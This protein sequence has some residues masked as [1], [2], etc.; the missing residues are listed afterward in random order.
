MIQHMSMVFKAGGL[1]V[2][3]GAFLMA[4]A[5]HTDAKGYV[6]AHMQQI[7]DE[8]HM[9][10]RSARD[11]RKRLEERELVKAAPRFSPKNNAQIANLFRINLDLLKSMERKRTDYGP[12]LVEEL[13]FE[14]APE[15]T[16]SSDPPAK[17]AAPSLDPPADLAPP[18]ADLAP[19][20]ADLAGAGAAKSAALL[21]PSS[22]P[23]SLSPRAGVAGDADASGGS[24]TV[25][26]RENEASPKGQNPS[27]AEVPQQREPSQPNAAASRIVAAYAAALGRPVLNGT[28]AKLER[29][30][31][32]LLAQEL[33][34]AWLCERAQEL[35]ARGWSDLVQHAERSTAPIEGQRAVYSSGRLDLPEWCGE[36]GE[37]WGAAARRNVRFRVVG[38]EG[39]QELCPRCHPSRTSSA[40][41]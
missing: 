7:A 12:S 41:A 1:S 25:G 30:A 39:S 3:E 10:L 5:N 18:P 17:S 38:S 9:S 28:R 32:E 16:P 2:G 20:P 14:K 31:V 19:P 23:S 13:T 34:E 33:P 29:Q 22:S 37:D 21:P 40:T 15:E 8:A 26:E 27:G 4:C 11:Q 24:T 6:I 35:A 36:C